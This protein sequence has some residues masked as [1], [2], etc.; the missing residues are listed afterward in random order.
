MSKKRK[1]KREEKP[2]MKEFEIIE[3]MTLSLNYITV[4]FPFSF[5]LSIF[6]MLV[7][8]FIFFF[9][10]DY[11][12]CLTRSPSGTTWI[13]MVLLEEMRVVY[14]DGRNLSLCLT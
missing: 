3:E 10:S 14:R 6:K 4:F 5:V 1:N 12:F 13:D 2:I 11:F 9:F 8:L 7:L